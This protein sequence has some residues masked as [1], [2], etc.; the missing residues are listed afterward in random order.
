MDEQEFLEFF[1]DE[2][3]ETDCSHESTEQM[4]GA[5]IC[6]IC[7]TELEQIYILQENGADC[8]GKKFFRKKNTK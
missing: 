7:G 3:E 6:S 5:V 4:N 8:M 2:D 1:A